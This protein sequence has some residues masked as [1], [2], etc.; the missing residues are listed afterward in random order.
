VQKD[1]CG[2]TGSGPACCTN[3]IFNSYALSLGTDLKTLFDAELDQLTQLLS[4]S[5]K[6][7]DSKSIILLIDQI[8]HFYFHL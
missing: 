5:N 6:E 8:N 3:E 4:F 2:K 7:I 1:A